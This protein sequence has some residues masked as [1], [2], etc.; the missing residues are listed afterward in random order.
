MRNLVRPIHPRIPG[1][2]VAMQYVGRVNVLQSPQNL[3][4]LMRGVSSEGEEVGRRCV[5][6]VGCKDTS[7]CKPGSPPPGPFSCPHLVCEVARVVLAESLCLQKLE[8]ISFHQPLHNVYIFHHV[9]RWRVDH[10]PDVDNLQVGTRQDIG[11]Q[12]VEATEAI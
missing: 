9:N 2:Q 4:Q 7:P 5:L 6:R 12:A 10:I 3:Q 11:A 1:L 8:Q